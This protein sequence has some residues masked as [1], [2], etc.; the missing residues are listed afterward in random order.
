MV[1]F[2]DPPPALLTRMLLFQRHHLL[3]QPGAN[4]CGLVEVSKVW[5]GSVGAMPGALAGCHPQASL[6]PIPGTCNGRGKL[7]LPG[8]VT[9]QKA[10]T[11]ASKAKPGTTE[12]RLNT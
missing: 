6:A 7:L 8:C 9:T 2:G 4:A 11:A 3:S 1:Y 10:L 12:G 5:V